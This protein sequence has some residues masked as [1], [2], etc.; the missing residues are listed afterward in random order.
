MAQITA[1]LRTFTASGRQIIAVPAALALL[2]A[3][4][5]GDSRSIAQEPT[6]TPAAAAAPA[7]LSQGQIDQLLAPI[8]LYPDNLL[9]QILAASTYPLDVVVAARWAA[10]NPNVTGQALEDA[11]QR[12][13]WDPSVKALAAVPQ[14]L[15]MMSE[16][17]EWTRE[18]GE[19]YLAQP[20]DIAASVQRLRAR[21]DASGNLK[22][23]SKLKVKRVKAPP[24]PPDVVYV[25]PPPPEYIVIEPYEPDVLFVPVYDPFIVYGVWPYPYYRP[26]YWYPPGYVRV[27][28]IGYGAPCLVGAAIWANYHWHSRRVVINVNHYNKYNHVKLANTSANQTWKFNS[29][30]RNLSF[31][32]AVLQKQ[33][34]KLGAGDIKQRTN[35]G[36]GGSQ[37]VLNTQGT[38]TQQ[39]IAK[40]NAKPRLNANQALN[41]SQR[42][43][44]N[45]AKNLGTQKTL[46]TQT[47]ITTRN[48]KL[49][50]GVS[51]L[52]K[53]VKPKNVINRTGIPKGANTQRVGQFKQNM[54]VRNLNVRPNANVRPNVNVRQNVNI[55]PR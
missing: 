16:K 36:P 33:Y 40:L 3:G 21:A 12:Q 45:A 28:V 53:N 19:A 43:N 34:G 38:G 9:G 47:N 55:K 30:R 44:P 49:N 31:K 46:G 8:A 50:P 15:Q 17:V 52:Q 37:K 20:D 1:V 41:P 10:A 13:N 7:A 22:E 24:P 18:L 14:V 39:G 6:A 29:E 48:A 5:F 42:L 51:N 35:F 23:T 11:M 26:F 2:M 4:V 27:A 54:S 25:E 32:N